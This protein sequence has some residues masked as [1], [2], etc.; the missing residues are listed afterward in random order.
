MGRNNEKIDLASMSLD[1]A[2]LVRAVEVEA[3]P[4]SLKDNTGL[5]DRLARAVERALDQPR[6]EV[7]LSLGWRLSDFHRRGVNRVR[8]VYYRTPEQVR[9]VT[10]E[11]TD[12]NAPTYGLAVDI[13][14][15]TL[16]LALV[17]LDQP[18]VLEQIT[19]PNPQAEFGPDILTR[20][21]FAETEGGLE[22]LVSALRR[23]LNLGAL[24]LCRG[25]GL[26]PERITAAAVAGNTSM[27]HFFLGLPVYTL[28]REPYTPII[29][30][31]QGLTAAQVGLNV[32]PE[33]PVLVMPN[34]G[35]YLGGD[36][37]AGLAAAGF[38]RAEEPCF[39]VDVGTNAEVVLGQKDWLVG[40]AG[41]AGPALEG[42]AAA[43]GMTAG[44]GAIDR[45]RIDRETKAL[46]WRTVDGGPPR[47]LC[48]SGLIDLLAELFLS[49]LIDFQGKL[50][51]PS[52]SPLRVETDEGPAFV[53]VP[54]EAAYDRKPILLSEVEIDILIRSKAAM[55]TILSTVL[56]SVGLEFHQIDKFYVAGAFGEFIDPKM[57]VAVG[58]LPDIPLE[59]YIPLGNSSLK[60]AILNLVS[61]EARD[62]VWDVWRRLTYLEMNV[63]QDLMNRFS[64]ARFIP[65]TE[66]QLFPSVGVI[67]K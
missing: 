41:A 60:G 59:K 65:H 1:H 23:G 24:E 28:I 35:A 52:G 10:L 61:Q 17:R 63:N 44:P 38:P 46:S 19:W 55:Y 37:M 42:G 2:P 21:H 47:G 43:M 33:A 54:A 5:V 14:S 49:G 8:V 26:D 32:S 58:M 53:V 36:L 56:E 18:A 3:P 12:T 16:F 66:R 34:K 62:Q 31:P 15:T 29:N 9:L 64:A 50:T 22:K 67:I 13:G 6:V 51:L 48:G 45:V 30:R 57:A 39:L 4:P 11:E 20:A 7:P 25:Y 40:A 27:T